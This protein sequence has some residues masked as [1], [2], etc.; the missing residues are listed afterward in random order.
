MTL[1]TERSFV[2][3]KVCYVRYDEKMQR[4]CILNSQKQVIS[5][6]EEE[7][8]DAVPAS[9]LVEISQKLGLDPEMD[10]KILRQIEWEIYTTYYDR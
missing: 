8:A 1:V 5:S 7:D 10:E 9:I 6:V 2:M 4:I 3:K